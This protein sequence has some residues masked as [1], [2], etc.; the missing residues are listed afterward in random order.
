MAYLT[1]VQITSLLSLEGREGPYS[2]LPEA[3]QLE[4]AELASARIESIP[5]EQ[6]ELPSPRFENGKITHTD[7]AMPRKLQRAVAVLALWYVENPFVDYTTAG[8]PV[9][10]SSLSPFLADLPLAVQTALWNYVS[11]DVKLG[12]GRRV[13][14]A[15]KIN[16]KDEL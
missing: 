3:R 11:Q 13:Q 10:P 1:P 9:D 6:I 14:E 7:L 4:L 2:E 8:A 15:G 12:R 16:L 5:F